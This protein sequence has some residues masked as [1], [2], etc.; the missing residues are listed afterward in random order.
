MHL[1]N[2]NNAQN[3]MFF[4]LKQAVREVMEEAGMITPF[5]TRAEVVKQ[6]GRHRYE[7]AVRSGLLD[8]NKAQGKSAQVRINRTEFIQLLNNGKI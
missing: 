2:T 4:L 1:N 3:E 5:I 8:R 7:K 6:I